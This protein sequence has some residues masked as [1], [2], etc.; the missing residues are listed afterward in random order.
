MPLHAYTVRAG[1]TSKQFLIYARGEEGPGPAVGLRHDQE[2]AAAAYVREGG[3]A[4]RIAISQGTVGQWHAGAFV[5]VDPDLVPGVYQ[6][7]APDEMLA[8]GA[9]RAV[10]VLRFPG[11]RIDPL[12]VDLVAFDPQ[13]SVRLGMS[14]LSP[15]ARVAALR[16]AFPR[17]ADREIQ[18]RAAMKEPD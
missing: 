3:G 4:R 12:E 18:E 17:L 6:F 5:E 15:E 8:P 2:G 1:T 10:L 13:D 16:G 14:A 11:A 7:G 9:T